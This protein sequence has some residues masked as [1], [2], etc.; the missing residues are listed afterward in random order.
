MTLDGLKT[1]LLRIAEIDNE[2]LELLRNDELE[3]VAS[4]VDERESRIGAVSAADP[5]QLEQLTALP[6]IDAAAILENGREVTRLVET[7]L[8]LMGNQLR[9][10]CESDRI[11]DGYAKGSPEVAAEL[12]RTTDIL[13]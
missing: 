11:L 1:Q 6:G 5:N 3:D 10:I 8:K 4:L 2:L 9:R 13:S 12:R 7:K